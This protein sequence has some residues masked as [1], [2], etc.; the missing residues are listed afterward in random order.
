M[1]LTVSYKLHL[2]TIALSV[3]QNVTFFSTNYYWLNY[4]CIVMPKLPIQ[5][6]KSSYVKRNYEWMSSS[7]FILKKLYKISDSLKKRFIGNVTFYQDLN[8]NFGARKW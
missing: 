5:V 1:C 2:Y 7:L 3:D 4:I 6:L 8:H